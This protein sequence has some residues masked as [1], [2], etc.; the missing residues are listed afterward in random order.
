MNLIKKQCRIFPLVTVITL[1]FTL[2]YSNIALAAIHP[3]DAEAYA[4]KELGIFNGREDGFALEEKP[5]RVE[6]A[7]VLLR[8]IG[9]E[10][11]ALAENIPNNFTD[12]PDWADAQIGYLYQNGLIKG[13]SETTFGN[14]PIDFDQMM[15]LILRA[16][17]YSEAAN[18]F[19]WNEAAQKAV[20]LSVLTPRAYAEINCEEDFTR[21][22]LATC[23]FYALQAT[24]KESDLTLIKTLANNS[25]FTEDQITNTGIADL[26]IAAGLKKDTYRRHYLHQEF[27]I[28]PT[29]PDA[30]YEMII[31]LPDN[32]YN[33]QRVIEHKFS[34]QPDEYYYTDGSFYAVYYLENIE[35]KT[36]LEIIS[37]V[38]ICLYDLQTAEELH[39]P[40]QLSDEDR[41]KY[42]T[43]S[44]WIDSDAPEFT[45]AQIRSTDG[46]EL[47]LV[48]ALMNYTTKNMRPKDTD[49]QASSLEAIHK[50][51]GDCWDYSVIFTSLCRAHGIP[52]R[53]ITLDCADSE[54]SGHAIVEVFLSDLG[55]VPF[56]PVNTD[57]RYVTFNRLEN[58]FIYLSDT[59]DDINFYGYYNENCSVDVKEYVS[60]K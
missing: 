8:L 36:K 11:E 54:A 4:L 45:E 19:V 60:D 39:Y 48:Q 44:S 16:L 23:M 24:V 3:D 50:G 20:E 31:N 43:P 15:T 53:V 30:Y 35:E 55:W 18:D 5:N 25:V 56:D 40:I 57:T 52:A 33:R 34:I 28:E 10:E 22:D 21:G 32:Y 29:G 1:L 27:T 17:G 46:S 14:N 7:V 6:A 42:T 13:M 12:V 51:S 47:D 41:E 49:G 58:N 59:L 37:E 38:E 26:L 2:F 9:K